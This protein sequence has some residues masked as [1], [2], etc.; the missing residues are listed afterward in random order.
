MGKSYR[1]RDEEAAMVQE[2]MIELIVKTKV[3]V[4]ES[5]IIHCL[6]RQGIEKLEGKE[7]LKY[8][9]EILGKED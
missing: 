1:L 5:D 3:A 6:I 2:K 9:E 8:R 4:K 7:V